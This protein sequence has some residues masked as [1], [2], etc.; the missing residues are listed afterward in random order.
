MSSKLLR[1]LHLTFWFSCLA[2][3]LGL[4]A[5]ALFF[6]YAFLVL[7]P[8]LLVGAI[9]GGV[10]DVTQHAGPVLAYATLCLLLALLFG[11][12]AFRVW[13]LLDPGPPDKPRTG[14]RWRP[15]VASISAAQGTSAYLPRPWIAGAAVAGAALGLA[16]WFPLADRV[17]G[18]VAP[19]GWFHQESD[20]TLVPQPTND[21]AVR[22]LNDSIRP[23]AIRGDAY[24]QWLL[25]ESLRN[26]LMGLKPDA[27]DAGGW[28]AK[29]A[30]QGDPDGRLS[31]I[32]GALVWDLPNARDS[33]LPSRLGQLP[34]LVEYASAS[35]GWRRVAAE[36]MLARG[37]GEAMPWIER[38]AR[39]GSRYAAFELAR[40]L[41]GKGEAP[42][43]KGP[44]LDDAYAWFAFAGADFRTARLEARFDA[45]GLVRAQAKAAALMKEMSEVL[46]A[47]EFAQ[48][49][50]NDVRRL[51]RRAQMVGV[52]VR[53]TGGHDMRKHDAH[54]HAIVHAEATGD[55]AGLAKFGD[56]DVAAWLHLLAAKKG[57]AGAMIEAA[58]L[59]APTHGRVPKHVEYMYAWNALAAERL[60]AA[61]SEDEALVA[62]AIDGRDRARRDLDPARL[63]DAEALLATLRASVPAP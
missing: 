14:G 1:A 58:R 31:L 28:I 15:A 49:T 38:A 39:H 51:E 27:S 3:L 9:I 62:A 22:E 11:A 21:A 42:G 7:S 26:G 19:V 56:E 37:P 36:M 40:E 63:R 60:Q 43:Y 32:T 24:A 4:L 29:S 30:A 6:G 8:L 25:G 52:R 5:Y 20:P 13:L 61:S 53:V 16:A 55:F 50:E 35:S 17:V 59:L 45:A 54:A 47:P 12:V 18:T 10:P 34:R 33:A 41:E 23:N 2:L 44:Y 48:P 57:G 46:R